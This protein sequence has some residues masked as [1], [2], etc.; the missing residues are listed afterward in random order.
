MIHGTR[1]LKGLGARA[2]ACQAMPRKQQSPLRCSLP[3]HT[4][5]LVFLRGMLPDMFGAGCLFL[6]VSSIIFFCFFLYINIYE[7]TITPPFH[8]APNC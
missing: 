2:K 8:P 6:H 5:G 3:P 4:C 1:W 7:S